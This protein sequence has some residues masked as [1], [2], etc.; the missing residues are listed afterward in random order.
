MPVENAES[1]TQSHPWTI[2]SQVASS[3]A[4]GEPGDSARAILSEVEECASRFSAVGEEA[5]IDL[6]CLKARPEER[7][8]LATLLGRGE[9]SAVV[10]AADRSEIHETSIPC[11]W[12]VRHW[13]E[14]GEIVGDSIEIT[15]VPDVL[16]GDRRAVAHGLEILRIA[17]PFR[18]RCVT[19][20]AHSN[21]G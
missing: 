1:D 15:D 8:I 13:N 4:C 19:H 16:M 12:W 11:V 2:P 10:A 20:G 5:S 6:R 17:W 18:M 14:E 3:T 21:N 7:D 9:V